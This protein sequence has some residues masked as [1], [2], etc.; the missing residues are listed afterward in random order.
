MPHLGVQKAV[1]QAPMHHGTTP[2]TS[3]D[4]DVEEGLKT[5]AA[6]QRC[7][8]SAAAFKTASKA[9]WQARARR[10][11]PPGQCGAQPVSVWR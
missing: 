10:A 5:L 7:S 11:S 1:E 6:P 4:R 9:D 3:A 8:A 2:D